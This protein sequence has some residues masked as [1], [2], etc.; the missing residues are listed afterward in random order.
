[1]LCGAYTGIAMQ[2][3]QRHQQF[4]PAVG[5]F[6]DQQRNVGDDDLIVR[7]VCLLLLEPP[8]TLARGIAAT[9]RTPSAARWPTP[10]APTPAQVSSASGP[11]P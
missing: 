5:A 3:Q 6:T 10:A 9:R 4:L 11:R 2:P 1:M 7:T 8:L